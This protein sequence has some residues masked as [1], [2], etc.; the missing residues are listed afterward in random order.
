MNQKN[1]ESGDS[2]YNSIA[3]VVSSAEDFSSEAQELAVQNN[4]R[5]I[6]GTEFRKMLVDAG[7]AKMMIEFSLPE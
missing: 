2:D 5:L 4:V 1:N 7:M 6:N 3:W